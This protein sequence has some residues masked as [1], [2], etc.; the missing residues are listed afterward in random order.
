MAGFFLRPKD[1]NKNTDGTL[2]AETSLPAAGVDDEF[3]PQTGFSSDTDGIVV[4]AHRNNPTRREAEPNAPLPTGGRPAGYTG[5]VRSWQ[6]P[7]SKTISSG[8]GKGTRA[9]NT[10]TKGR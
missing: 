2:K 8:F 7:A 5:G 6:G 4:A 10:G 3:I 9:G 1:T